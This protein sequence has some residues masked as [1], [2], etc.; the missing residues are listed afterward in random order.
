MLQS[1]TLAVPCTEPTTFAPS[2]ETTLLPEGEPL[3]SPFFDEHDRC[4]RLGCTAEGL[5]F[6][7]VYFVTRPNTLPEPR[8]ELTFALASPAGAVSTYPENPYVRWNMDITQADTVVDISADIDVAHQVLLADGTPVDASHSGTVTGQYVV[9]QHDDEVTIDITLAFANIAAG[10]A[11]VE[12]HGLPD[13]T[14]AGFITVDGEEVA[15]LAGPVD[16]GSA[17]PFAWRAGCE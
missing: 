5:Y 8:H 2:C 16:L 9:A 10:G 7:D 12:V 6:V 11:V 1:A 3:P 15:T 4:F 17:L 14:L 13:G